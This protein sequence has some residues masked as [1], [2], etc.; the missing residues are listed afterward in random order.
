MTMNEI[1]NLHICP[2]SRSR[3]CSPCCSCTSSL[4]CSCPCSTSR[5]SP[6]SGNELKTQIVKGRTVESM[7]SQHS[8]K[9]AFMGFYWTLHIHKHILGHPEVLTRSHQFSL[10]KYLHFV[11]LLETLPIIQPAELQDD[12][13]SVNV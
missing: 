2:Y 5:Y 4:S 7:K 1:K 13:V 8:S 11:W 12:K 6:Q 9:E 3:P 10:L